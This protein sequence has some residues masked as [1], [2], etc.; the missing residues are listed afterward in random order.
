MS[1]YSL[2]S[3]ADIKHMILAY[4]RHIL[5]T[6]L[7]TDGQKTRSTII[8]WVYS[9]P[10]SIGLGVAENQMLCYAMPC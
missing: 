10:V 6:N 2:K 7:F 5:C 4:H 8:S 3:G 1:F 9:S